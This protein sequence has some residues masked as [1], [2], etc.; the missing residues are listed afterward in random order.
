[1]DKSQALSGDNYQDPAPP[2]SETSNFASN[3]D[4]KGSQPLPLHI[5]LSQSRSQRIH[6]IIQI[7]IEPLLVTQ[8]FSGIFKTTFLL[9]PSNVTALQHPHSTPDDIIEG[10]GS[11]HNNDNQDEIVGF[12]ASE[13]VKLVRLHGQEHTAEFWRQPAV[14]SELESSLEARLEAGGHRISQPPSTVEAPVSPQAPS[15]TAEK[16]QSFW[17]RKKDKDASTSANAVEED[18]TRNLKL[19][20]RAEG[21]GDTGPAFGETRV[22]VGLKEV[23]LRVVTEMG[24]YET[25]TGQAVGIRVEVGG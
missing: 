6:E 25:R 5:Q 12:P 20:W 7:Y 24:L 16:K 2:Y 9:V 22:T 11:A 8:G 15:P 18:V 17:S 19:G 21:E 14:L 23:C 3:L 10:T 1:M 13:Y 4:R